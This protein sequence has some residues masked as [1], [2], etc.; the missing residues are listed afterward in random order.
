M[1]LIVMKAQLGLLVPMC[2]NL[3]EMVVPIKGGVLV[4]KGVMEFWHM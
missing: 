2:H 4:W 1:L 3:V